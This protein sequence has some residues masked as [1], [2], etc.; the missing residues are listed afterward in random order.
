MNK[1]T[2]L[3]VRNLSAFYENSLALYNVSFDIPQG[4]RCAIIGPNGA[5]KTT[6]LKCMLELHQPLLGTTAFFGKSFSE[7]R[8]HIA[9]IPQKKTI[10]WTFP[11]TVYETVLMGTYHLVPFFKPLP[12]LAHQKVHAALQAVNLL[13]HA[14]T[15]IE[16]LS[17]GQQQRVFLARALAQEATIYLM[18]E[19]FVGIDKTTEKTIVNIFASLQQKNCTFFVVHHDWHTIT[20][21][22]DWVLFIN[23]EIL[24]CGPIEECDIQLYLEKTF[25]ESVMKK[26][27]C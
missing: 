2:A 9:Y 8:D 21:Y 11:I 3:S 26:I 22:F 24:Y 7:T 23:Q 17:G 1:K 20:S 6:L 15:R 19:P 18:D 12:K 4:V 16:N 27:P 13:E 5:G 14:Q 25:Q 10:D